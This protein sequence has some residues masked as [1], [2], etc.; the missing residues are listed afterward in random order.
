[1]KDGSELINTEAELCKQLVIVARSGSAE[2][3]FA[4]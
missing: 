4:S 2:E 1:M 3:D